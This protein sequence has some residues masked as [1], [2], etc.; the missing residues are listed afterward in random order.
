MPIRGPFVIPRR[1]W[2][3]MRQQWLFDVIGWRIR[4]PGA[5]TWHN[6]KPKPKKRRKLDR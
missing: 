3:M 6:R 1:S 4:F 2:F 5:Y